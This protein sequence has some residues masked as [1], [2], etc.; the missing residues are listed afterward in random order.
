MG[1]VTAITEHSLSVKTNDS[2]VATV[3]FDGE[4]RFV[5]ATPQPRSRTSG[6]E[7]VWS[8]TA[9]NVT[10]RCSRRP[11]QDRSKRNPASTRQLGL[12]RT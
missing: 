11:S 2:A 6:K 1:T 8:F 9:T 3:E 10:G 4:T 7:A 5:K 12:E